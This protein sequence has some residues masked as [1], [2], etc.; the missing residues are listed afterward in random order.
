MNEVS[1]FKF[2]NK[3]RDFPF[4]N[5]NPK[6]SK[7]GWFVLW[8]SIFVSVIAYALV[9]EVCPEII[10]SIVFVLIL[11]IPVLYFCNWDISIL[12]QKPKLKEVGLAILLFAG[13][14][15]Y[16][17]AIGE[18]LSFFGILSDESLANT[19]IDA[20][21]II[22]LFFS[23]MAEEFL[24]FIPFMFFMRVIYKFSN[25]RKLAIIVSMLL[26]MVGFA[27]MH[28]TGF[29]FLV[30]VLVI[31]GFGSIFEF[32]GYI[33][34]KNLLIPYITHLTTDVFIFLMIL[35]GF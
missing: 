3:D 31:Q 4:Y 10:A 21:F 24:K 22:S 13:Y 27:L 18:V 30:S 9:G 1:W 14:M 20:L 28:L 17:F 7:L 6:I 25:N 33:K 11:I 26:V 35:L 34:T 23:L 12:F 5:N 2:E 15:V 8:L 19:S 29:N 32:Y 16:A